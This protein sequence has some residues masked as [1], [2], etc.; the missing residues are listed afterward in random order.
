MIKL[1][2]LVYGQQ[3]DYIPD[4][5]KVEDEKISIRDFDI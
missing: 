2:R 4:D 1:L 5:V 3:F